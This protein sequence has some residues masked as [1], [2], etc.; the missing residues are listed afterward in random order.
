MLKDSGYLNEKDADFLNRIGAT[1]HKPALPLYGVHAAERAIESFSSVQFS[2]STELPGGA[3]VT[4]RLAGHILGAATA[5]VEWAGRRIVFSGDLGRYSD[6]FMLDPEPV[7]QAD[8][9]VIESTYGNRIHDTTDAAAALGAVVE[10]HVRRS[11]TV[12]L[13]PLALG[14]APADRKSTRLHSS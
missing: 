1:R 6:P 2:K 11:V 14:R 4:F 9:V 5:D 3:R 7:A 8:F 10:L 12:I 13:T